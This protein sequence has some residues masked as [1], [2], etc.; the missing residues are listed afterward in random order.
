M[1]LI[2]YFGFILGGKMYP[3]SKA[4]IWQK[5]KFHPFSLLMQKIPWVN[6]SQS[7]NRSLSAN[8]V[9]INQEIIKLGKVFTKVTQ[10]IK[11]SQCLVGGCT[12]E[13]A[14]SEVN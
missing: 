7:W 1:K 6:S 10:H 14:K 12:C 2:L 5:N 8:F 3:Q 13:D 4:T 11:F 9:S